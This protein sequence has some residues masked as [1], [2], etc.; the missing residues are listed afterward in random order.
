MTGLLAVQRF[1]Q[2]GWGWVWWL[3]IVFLVLVL[4][5][6]STGGWWRGRRP[7]PRV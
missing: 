4:V 5:F 1:G 3:V 2:T 7:P 6:G